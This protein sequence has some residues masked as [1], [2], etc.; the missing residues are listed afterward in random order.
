MTPVENKIRVRDLNIGESFIMDNTE[1]VVIKI[2]S[3][4]IFYKTTLTI[5]LPKNNTMSKKSNKIII[6]LTT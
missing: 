5:T 1:Y 3:G 6:R 4:L 2:S